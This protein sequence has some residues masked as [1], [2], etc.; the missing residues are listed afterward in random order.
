MEFCI[1]GGNAGAKIYVDNERERDGVLYFDVH[2]LLAEEAVPETFDV[3]FSTPAVDVYSVWSPSL[4]FDRH[5]GPAFLKRATYSRLASWMPLHA[6]VSAEGKNRLTVTLSDAETPVGLLSGIKEESANVDWVIRFF[7]DLVSPRTEYTATVRMDMRDIPYC[8]AI[9]DAITWWE[10]DC[11]YTP[12]Y[13]PEHAKLPMNSLWYSYHQRLDVEDIL[14]ECALSK[15]IGMDTVIVDDGWQTEDNGRGYQFCGDWEVAPSKIPDMKDFVR[16]VH[17]TGMKIMLWFSVPYIGTGAKNYA[18]FADMILDNPLN[19]RPHFCLDPRYK[20]VREFL[21]GIY[22]RA[23]GEWGFDGLKLDFIDAFCLRGKSLE[24]D[25]RRDY[26]SLEDAI[27]ALMLEVNER[28]RRINP[29]VLIEFRQSYVGP[30]IRKYGN[31]LRV[32][33]CPNDAI[34]NRQDTVNLRLTSGNTAVHSDMIMWNR[35]DRVESAALQFASILYSVPQ[36]SVKL[37]DLR[38]DHRKMLAFYLSFWRENRDV[39][40]NGSLS[41]ANPESAYSLV[42]AAK[43][44]TAILT[45]YTDTRIDCAPYTRTVA[46]NATRYPTLLL[47]GADKK[48]YRTLDCMG[49]ILEEG[50]VCGALCEVRVPLAGMIEI[51]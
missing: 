14:C 13:V 31:M 44:G 22:E 8:D 47:T 45:A 42:C 23:V 49:N 17:D 40:L 4:R 25:A 3:L 16:R 32:G 10:Q 6:L 38:E 43:D 2:M 41:A 28:L 12:A 50:T 11:G 29:D 18:R 34:C 27:D 21:I 19:K 48:T 7:T 20:E 26:V 5:L 46:V 39:L 37:A 36:I 24:P 9:R 51:F 35:E 33:D 15:A 1:K 30:A